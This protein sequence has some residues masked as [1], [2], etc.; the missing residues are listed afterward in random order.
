M[1]PPRGSRRLM[2]GVALGASFALVG[3]VV[4]GPQTKQAGSHSSA[5]DGG[6]DAKARGA[7]RPHC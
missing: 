5:D 6:T 4:A 1:T 7:R 2:Q 3:L